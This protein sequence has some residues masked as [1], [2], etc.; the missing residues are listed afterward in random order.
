MLAERELGWNDARLM[1]WSPAEWVN[2]SSAYNSARKRHPDRRWPVLHWY[3]FLNE[4]VRKEPVTVRGA[5]DFSLKSIAKAMHAA[6]LIRTDWSDGPTDGLGAM[7]GAWW[8]AR[9]A[10]RSGVSMRQLELMKEI[11]VY[12]EVDCRVMAEIIAWL[13]VNR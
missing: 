9:E 10:A 12:N 5:F 7:V 13:R 6:G 11:G 4:V 3:D 1:H 8:C 2:L